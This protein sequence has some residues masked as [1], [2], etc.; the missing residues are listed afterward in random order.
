MFA[1]IKSLQN[2]VQG[3]QSSSSHDNYSQKNEKIPSLMHISTRTNSAHRE[4]LRSNGRPR[5]ESSSQRKFQPHTPTIPATNHY[6]KENESSQT[7]YVS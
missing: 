4:K 3:M 5:I 2:R 6:V 7:K 1:A